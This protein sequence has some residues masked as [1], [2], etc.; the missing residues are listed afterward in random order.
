MSW[1]TQAFDAAGFVDAFRVEIL[2][3]GR[4]PARRPLQCR[5]LGQS[6]DPRLVLRP[7]DRR[8]AHRRD[9]QGRGRA[10]LAPRAPGHDDLPGVGRG[11]ADRHR[12]SER[13]DHR[14]AGAAPAARRA[15]GRSCD[16]ACAQFRGEH[17]R[18]LFGD[19]LSGAADRARRGRPSLKDCLRRRPGTVGPLGDQV[20]LRSANRC[21]RAQPILAEARAAGPSLRRRLRC[22]AGKLGQSARARCGTTARTRSANSG[23]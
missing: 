12:R 7:A 8:S 9:H 22:A 19:G 23:G 5:Q 6:R 18:A 3:R 16:R 2:P 10:R 1:W 11:R 21:R 20:A 4:R 17:A 13:S 15:R 14:D